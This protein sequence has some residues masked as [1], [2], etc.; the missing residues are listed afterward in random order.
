LEDHHPEVQVVGNYH[1]EDH[2]LEDQVAGSCHWEDHYLKEQAAGRYQ[3]DSF[4]GRHQEDHHLVEV[5]A[6][7]CS[8]QELD[9]I[10]CTFLN[11]RQ[12]NNIPTVSDFRQGSNRE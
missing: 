3:E 12:M 6:A 7:D 11:S 4:V 5:V 1:L 10:D 2:H 8:C 9:D